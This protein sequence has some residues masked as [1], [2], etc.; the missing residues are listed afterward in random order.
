[1]RTVDVNYRRFF[2]NRT[3]HIDV[4]ERWED[5]KPHQFEVCAQLHTN[6][7][8][9]QEFIRRFFGLDNKL[10]KRLSKFE[11]YKLTEMVGFAVTP[12]ATTSHFYMQEISGTGLLSPTNRLGNM[13][14]EHFALMDTYFFK[15]VNKP[16][17]SRMCKFVASLYLKKN[18]E[19]TAIDFTKRVKSVEKRVDKSTLYAIFLNYLFVRKW[20]A[21]SFSHLFDDDGNEEETPRKRK[22]AKPEKAVKSLPKWVD[23]IDNFVGDDVLHYDQYTHMNCLRAFKIINNRIK[24]YKKNGK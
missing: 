7:P 2:R 3:H 20:L 5:L 16:T 13:T 19:L 17:E 21:Q 11:I 14:L 10:I 8:S 12:A 18:E 4:P 9:D 23:I 6:P 24:N 1:M 15:Y 22:F